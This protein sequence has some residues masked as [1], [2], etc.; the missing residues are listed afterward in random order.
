MLKEEEYF[1]FVRRDI[2][3]SPATARAEY[4]PDEANAKEKEGSVTAIGTKLAEL[5]AKALR[6]DLTTEEQQL[7][8]SYTRRLESAEQEFQSALGVLAKEINNPVVA[9]TI[10]EERGLM[11]DL[12]ELGAGT[13]ALN[14]INSGPNSK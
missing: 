13:V 10:E 14:R 12:R 2:N 6:A 11:D 5:E 3:I 9:G 1:D 7:R 8:V 4:R